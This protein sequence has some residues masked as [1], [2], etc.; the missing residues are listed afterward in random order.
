MINDHEDNFEIPSIEDFSPEY[1]DELQE[2][3]TSRR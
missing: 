1:I 2:D 3:W